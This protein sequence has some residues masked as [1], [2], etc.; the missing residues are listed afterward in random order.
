MTR[1][2][3]AVFLA[4]LW[5]CLAV[6]WF[7]SGEQFLDLVFDMPDAGPVDDLAIAVTVGA[8]D[9]R[10]A[11]SPPDLFAALRRAIHGLTGLN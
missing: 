2:D 7:F 8:E 6:A 5:I 3:T 4:V 10:A 1:T 9:V 11:V